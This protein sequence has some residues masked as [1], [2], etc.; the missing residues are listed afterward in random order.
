MKVTSIGRKPFRLSGLHWGMLA[1][2]GGLF[3]L[4]ATFVDLSPV[5]DEN[6][7]P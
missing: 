4:V 1:I 7:P 5:V 2:V 6:F 3:G